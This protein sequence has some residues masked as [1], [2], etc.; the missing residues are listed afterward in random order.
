MSY[1]RLDSISITGAD[2]HGLNEL[3]EEATEHNV[4]VDY[5]GNPIAM[6]DQPSSQFRNAVPP[7]TPGKSVSWK[8]NDDGVDNI[9]DFADPKVRN[10]AR[11]G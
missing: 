6:Y 9:F 1:F 4:S 2:V 11:Y 10:I 8:A 3:L 7:G 5:A